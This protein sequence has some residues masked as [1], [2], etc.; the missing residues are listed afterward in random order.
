MSKY[1]FYVFCSV[2]PLFRLVC[3]REI[4]IGDVPP[5][6]QLF[7]CIMGTAAP[8]GHSWFVRNFLAARPPKEQRTSVSA[9]R[10]EG[11]ALKMR[12]SRQQERCFPRRGKHRPPWSAR[13]ISLLHSASRLVAT[14][15]SIEH[16]PADGGR[17]DLGGH[18]LCGRPA[19]QG[20]WHAWRAG[21][22]GPL[23]SR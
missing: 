19:E 11:N 4:A 14:H 16:S 3:R 1:Q 5:V 7:P 8:V 15:A 18:V 10:R 23:L 13:K 6:A 2:L 12:G 17:D 20:R 9:S 21:S 22:L